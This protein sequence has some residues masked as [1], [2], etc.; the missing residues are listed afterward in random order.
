MPS[1]RRFLDRLGRTAG[2]AVLAPSLGRVLPAPTLIERARDLLQRAPLIDTHNDLPS[3]LL[4]AGGDLARL[5]L[6][7]PQPAL[8]ADVP[9]LREGRVG[10]QYWSV[11]VESGTQRTHDSLHESLRA[12]DVALRLIRSQPDFAQARSADDIERIHAAGRIACLLGVEGG[13]TM[14]NSAAALRI[15]H[16]LGARYMTLTHWDNIDWAD[17]ATDRPEHHGLTQFG[18]QTIREMNRLGLFA[19]V[20]HVSAEA[21]RDTLS[22]TR[23]PVVFSHSGAFAVNPHPRN[24]PDDVLRQLPRNGGVVH[25]NFIKE[26]VSPQNPAWAER[27]GAAL[28]ELHARLVDDQA[29]TAALGEWEKANPYPTPT[30]A[31]VAD[32]V[33][34]IRKVAGIDHVG[35][36]ADFFDSGKG[37]MVAG[38]EDVTRYPHLFA[39]LLARGYSDEDVLKVAGR[40]HLRAMREMER[41]AAGLQRS[42]PPFLGEGTKP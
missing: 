13:H 42:E 29:I 3:M 33:D 25:V 15:F 4:E 10:A 22:V 28:R 30:V 20:S 14:E 38:L 27:R 21:M 17:S 35:I 6:G 7:R 37:S 26:F 8:C 5:D 12:F 36:G 16:E 24:V 23:A 32:H 31:D 1:R 9:R 2:A 34:H 40:N 41:V 18:K 19:D 11:F 39:E